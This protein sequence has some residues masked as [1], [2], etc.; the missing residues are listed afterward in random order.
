MIYLARMPTKALRLM[1]RLE[2]ERLRRGVSQ[3][4]FAA[5]IGMSASNYTKYKKGDLVL[6]PLLS[7]LERFAKG[8]GVSVGDLVSDEPRQPAPL[9][10]EKQVAL[11]MGEAVIRIWNEQGQGRGTQR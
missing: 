7:T 3:K 9:P 2:E 4:E 5:L 1:R 11:E 8:L 6:D 10:P